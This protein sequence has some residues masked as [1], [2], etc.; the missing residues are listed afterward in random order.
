MLPVLNPI[1]E[2]GLS[3]TDE[4]VAPPSSLQ[5]TDVHLL[6]VEKMPSSDVYQPSSNV[7]TTNIMSQSEA[8][9]ELTKKRELDVLVEMFPNLKQ[10]RIE[11]ALESAGSDLGRAINILLEENHTGVFVCISLG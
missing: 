8:S 5:Q 3:C 6:V 10:E 4:D 9:N 1:V 11:Q 7:D 2:P